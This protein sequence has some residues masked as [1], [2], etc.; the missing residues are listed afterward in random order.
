M[1]YS[2][3]RLQPRNTRIQTRDRGSVKHVSGHPTLSVNIDVT[4]RNW[5]HGNH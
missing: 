1:I 4:K 2:D 3:K 5:I